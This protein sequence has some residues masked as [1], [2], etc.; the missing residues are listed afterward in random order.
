MPERMYLSV[1]ISLLQNSIRLKKS[2]DAMGLNDDTLGS[3]MEN[4]SIHC[5]KRVI[6]KTCK[7]IST[8]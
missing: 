4:V 8:S 5:F 7:P 6:K 2:S 1:H 3:L